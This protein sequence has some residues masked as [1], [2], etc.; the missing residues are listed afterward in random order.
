MKLKKI[1]IFS[2]SMLFIL[3]NSVFG[4]IATQEKHS[5]SFSIGEILN[6]SELNKYIEYESPSSALAYLNE[7]AI[8]ATINE[9]YLRTITMPNGSYITDPIRYTE[10]EY[11]A[12]ENQRASRDF[13]NEHFYEN[14][15]MRLKL[16]AYE[17]YSGD[18]DFY[19]FYSWKTKPIFTRNDIIG[20]SYPS[21]LACD[22]T[23]ASSFHRQ[24]LINVSTNQAIYSTQT[25]NSTN[26]SNFK[27]SL[28]GLAF[29][30][31][32]PSSPD[33]WPTYYDGYLNVKGGFTNSSI[34]ATT[35]ELS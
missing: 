17:L 13:N 34:N 22:S 7:N 32:L 12:L 1:I 29:K 10:D 35:I 25:Y 14:S 24:T 18:Y 5:T 20:F 27:S 3:S 30:F 21:T 2:M 26:H 15:W 9:Y 6:C 28:N 31:D 11:M 8:S 19:M 23:S 33:M 16:E 4:N